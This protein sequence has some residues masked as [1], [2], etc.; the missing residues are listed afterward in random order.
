MNYACIPHSGKSLDYLCDA[1]FIGGN[2]YR[3]QFLGDE[4]WENDEHCY[5]AVLSVWKQL[6]FKGSDAMKNVAN[7]IDLE[8]GSQYHLGEGL[9]A[10]GTKI[11]SPESFCLPCGG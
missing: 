6:H 4:L 3:T 9:F 11:H 1:E 2:P 5:P 8:C 10:L 7:D